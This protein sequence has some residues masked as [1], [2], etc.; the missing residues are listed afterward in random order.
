MLEATSTR[1][2]VELLP[3]TSIL[4]IDEIR[5][6]EKKMKREKSEEER[7]RKVRKRERERKNTLII[8]V[9]C[10]ICIILYT[11]HVILVYASYDEKES[12]TEFEREKDEDEKK[13]MKMG[14][15]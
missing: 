12:Q 3:S 6:C 4:N 13:K 10:D 1:T 14:R 2:T 5:R 7:E 9:G 8:R 11:E 15:R